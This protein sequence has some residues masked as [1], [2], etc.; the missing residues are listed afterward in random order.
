[1][2]SLGSEC[3][4]DLAAPIERIRRR[5]RIYVEEFAIEKQSKMG[6][7]RASKS[8][9][10]FFTVPKQVEAQFSGAHRKLIIALLPSTHQQSRSAKGPVPGLILR[11]V[12]NKEPRINK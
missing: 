9:S 12:P 6:C 2:D 3:A 4:L 1:M 5:S 10:Y 8:T 7:N 11:R